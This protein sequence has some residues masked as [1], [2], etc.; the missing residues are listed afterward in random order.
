MKELHSRAKAKQAAEVEKQIRA[1]WSGIAT[2]PARAVAKEGTQQ[3]MPS[4]GEVRKAMD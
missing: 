3:A 4:H 1:L 2:S